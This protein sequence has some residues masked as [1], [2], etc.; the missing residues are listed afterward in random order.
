MEMRLRRIEAR[1]A[2]RAPDMY[3][4]FKNEERG[5]PGEGTKQQHTSRWRRSELLSDSSSLTV[6]A[7]AYLL[8]DELGVG[9]YLGIISLRLD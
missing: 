3:A 6:P 2:E 8:A 9:G 4:A 7:N 5:S 1:F